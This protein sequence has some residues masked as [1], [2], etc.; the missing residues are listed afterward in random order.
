MLNVIPAKA[1]ISCQK[2]SKDCS[3]AVLFV[4]EGESLPLVSVSTRPYNLA[5][6]SMGGRFVYNPP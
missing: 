3:D 2:H 6:S 4:Y 5:H 1:G